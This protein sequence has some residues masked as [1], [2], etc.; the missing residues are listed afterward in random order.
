MT[1][2]KS[3]IES[4]ILVNQEDNMQFTYLYTICLFEALYDIPSRNE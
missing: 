3:Y 2:N 1:R 4:V